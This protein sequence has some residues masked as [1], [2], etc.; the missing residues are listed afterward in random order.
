MAKFTYLVQ[1]LAPAGV[2]QQVIEQTND[3]TVE[4]D[5]TIASATDALINVAFPYATI[6]AIAL[7]CDVAVT[8]ETNSSSS[9]S[10]TIALVANVPNMWIYGGPGSNP[11][12]V[13]VTKI[14]ATAAAAGTLKIRVLYDPTP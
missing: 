9:P 11:I 6:K 12:T 5:V 3:A 7:S 4:M 2:V 14:Y 1:M 8:L 10:Q 13:D